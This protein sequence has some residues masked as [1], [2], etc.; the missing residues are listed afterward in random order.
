[1]SLSC[2]L[3][4]LGSGLKDDARSSAWTGQAG[5]GEPTDAPTRPCALMI[6]PETRDQQARDEEG[7][8]PPQAAS[9][10]VFGLVAGP[11]SALRSLNFE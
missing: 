10:G 9:H 6:H 4:S 8:D 1:M 7:G 5:G 3:S 2:S 11:S